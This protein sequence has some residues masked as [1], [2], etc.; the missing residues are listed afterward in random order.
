MGIE[1][2]L[3]DSSPVTQ[4]IFFH[5]LYH[6]R[7]IVHRID[8]TSKLIEK[9][10]YSVPDIIFIDAAFSN[11]I[12]NQI[13][14]KKEKFKNIP[15]ILIAKKDLNQEE[16]E[17]SI[18]KGVLK[19]PIEAGKL[20]KLVNHFVPKTKRNILTEHL[21][22]SPIPDFKEGEN[23]EQSSDFSSKTTMKQAEY[24]QELLTDDTDDIYKSPDQN[25]HHDKEKIQPIPM[26]ELSEQD[27]VSP[28][29]TSP[30][31][32]QSEGQIN[33]VT[34]TQVLNDEED[35]SPAEETSR[36]L[37]EDAINPVTATESHQQPE[38]DSPQVEE[39]KQPSWEDAIKPV[40]A[41]EPHQQPEDEPAP[42]KQESHP[43]T[44]EILEDIDNTKKKSATDVKIVQIPS[45]SKPANKEKSSAEPDNINSK[46]QITEDIKLWAD[47]TIKEEV[48]KQLEQ[49]IR[50]NSQNTIQ[51]ITEKAVWQVV[52]ELAKQLITKELDKLLKEE[53]PESSNTNEE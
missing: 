42:P 36:Q 33:P 18:V 9:I 17:S 51:T 28:P 4:K 11:D 2:I 45:D 20:R 46:K 19:K 35:S 53:D 48:E 47:K 37:P 12:E 6:Y 27:H 30:T 52:P 40:T 16:L 49:I 41:A 29:E 44:E 15:I 34:D 1:I 39:A 24:K 13:N 5:I 22:F 23:P 3:Y 31:P 38:D 25:Q 50:K 10:Q 43:P 32:N 14:E 21:K 26:K 7:P 8:Q